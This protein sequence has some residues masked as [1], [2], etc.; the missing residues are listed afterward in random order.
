V[1]ERIRAEGIEIIHCHN[2]FPTLGAGVVEAAS[3]AGAAVVLT[4]HNYRLMCVA[5]TFFRDGRVC[6]DCLGRPRWPGVVHGC[7]R[8]SRAQSAVLSTA[9]ARARGGAWDRVDRFLAVSSFIR[10]KHVEAGYPGE[11]IVVKPNVVPA[12]VRRQAPGDYFLI[13]SRLS[14]EKGITDVVRSWDDGLGELRIAGDGPKRSEIERLAVGRGVRVEG[15]VAPS[16]VAALLAGARA[17]LLPSLWYEGHPRVLLEAY[18]A[19]VPVVASRIGSLADAVSEGETGLTVTPGDGDGWRQ[20]ARRLLD[21][22]VSL[23]MGE[24]AF[25]SWA[26]HFSPERGR[27]ALEDAYADAL[28]A[29]AR[30]GGA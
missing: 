24:C 18:A 29:R 19:G 21:D 6:E 16:E 5:G 30:R 26:A 3:K 25:A 9:L 17:L 15:P 7:Y 14:V 4:L 1:S 12:Q 13:L 11:R 2:L 22:D 10:R 8:G 28:D 20:A 23:R 27:A